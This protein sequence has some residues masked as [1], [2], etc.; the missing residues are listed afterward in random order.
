M[1][2]QD[3]GRRGGAGRDEGGRELEDRGG[4]R[5]DQTARQLPDRG[6]PASSLPG[7]ATAYRIRAADESDPSRCEGG[8]HASGLPGER[9]LLG[10]LAQRAQGG[11]PTGKTTSSSSGFP[12]RASRAITSEMGAFASGST[13]PT[14]AGPCSCAMFPARD[15]DA[16]RNGSRG[17][18]WAWTGTRRSP[19]RIRRRRTMTTS[20][21]SDSPALA[22]GFKPIPVDKIGPYQ[23]DLRASWPIV[24]ARAP[25]NTRSFRLADPA[26]RGEPERHHGRQINDP[27][28]RIILS[29]AV[30]LIP[31]PDAGETQPAGRPLVR[32]HQEPGP[33]RS[34]LRQVGRVEI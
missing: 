32:D 29:A 18:P 22:L 1:A 28:M 21:S 25:A 24:E 12:A 23:D 15:R 6:Q 10:Q 17:S 20:G 8:S 13:S 4:L 30:V 27:I 34:G 26:W 14:P 9:L 16:G 19:T 11:T 7:P 3:A 31:P 33:V 5:C 2:D